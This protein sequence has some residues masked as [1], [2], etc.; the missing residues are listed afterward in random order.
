VLIPLALIAIG[1]DDWLGVSRKFWFESG[2]ICV[3][4]IFGVSAVIL[5]EHKGYLVLPGLY[6]L[7]VFALPFLEMSPVKPAVRIVEE[8]RPG[9]TEAEIRAIVDRHFPEHGRFKRPDIGPLR[10]DALGFILDPSDGR[11]NAAIV[12]IKFSSGKCV[13]SEF[14]PD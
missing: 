1:L 3:G 13:S 2:F 10:G 9:M 6:L 7:F 5:G 8:I 4:A 14:L 12:Q 11:Y